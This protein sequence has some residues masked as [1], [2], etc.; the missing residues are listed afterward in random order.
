MDAVGMREGCCPGAASSGVA[1]SGAALSGF[2]LAES[3]FC[4][5]VTVC[6]VTGVASWLETAGEVNA[7]ISL[8][9]GVRSDV[10]EMIRAGSQGRWFKG[11]CEVWSVEVMRW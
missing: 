7:I 6:G 1:S 3:D 4:A 2:S 10:G 11:M 5:P 9:I 8:M